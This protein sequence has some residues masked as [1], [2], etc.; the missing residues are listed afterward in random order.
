MVSRLMALPVDCADPDLLADFWAEVLGWRV[1]GRGWQQ[2]PQGRTGA[3]LS[4]GGRSPIE[5]DFRWV[6]DGPKTSKNRIHLDISP[7]DREQAAELD[8]L[9]ALGA[10][11]LDIGQQRVSWHVLADPEGNEFCLCRDRVEPLDRDAL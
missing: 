7:V 1:T 2:A 4:P 11:L 9:L 6:P 3:T 5:M 10:T 8:R